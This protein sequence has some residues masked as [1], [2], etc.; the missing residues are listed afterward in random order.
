M[1]SGGLQAAVLCQAAGTDPN[2]GE[3]LGRTLKGLILWFVGSTKLSQ[4]FAKGAWDLQGSPGSRAVFG[5]MA[6]GP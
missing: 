2:T 3:V 6:G 4:N 5:P 1:T